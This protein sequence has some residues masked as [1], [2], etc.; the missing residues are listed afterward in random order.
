MQSM[1]ACIRSIDTVDSV[2]SV[3]FTCS[4]ILASRL[5]MHSLVYNMIML[6]TNHTAMFDLPLNATIQCVTSECLMRY[7][8]PSQRVLSFGSTQ[9]LYHYVPPAKWLLGSSHEYIV[10]AR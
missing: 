3:V 8:F 5:I 10:S 9:V 2:S 1:Q 4:Y 7:N 6:S